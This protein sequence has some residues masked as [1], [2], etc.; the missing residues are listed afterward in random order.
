MGERLDLEG[1]ADGTS[2]DVR[3]DEVPGSVWEFGGWLGRYCIKHRI[4]GR[5]TLHQWLEMST[6]ARRRGITFHEDAEIEFRKH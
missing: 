1:P 3:E 4:R 5:P 6:E 2:R